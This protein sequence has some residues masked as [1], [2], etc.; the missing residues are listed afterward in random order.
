MQYTPNK[1][2]DL[3][4]VSV[5]RYFRGY[6]RNP[7]LIRGAVGA[8]AGP[9]AGRRYLSTIALAHPVARLSNPC[10]EEPVQLGIKGFSNAMS[11]RQRQAKALGWAEIERFLKSA[12]NTLPATRERALLCVA[13]DTM[14]RR[15]E[16]VALDLEDFN[17]LADGTGRALIR[18]SKTD[19]AGEGRI[20]YPSRTT[21]R[22]LNL[23]PKLK[24]AG[25][26]DGA[27]FRRVFGR[28]R[29]GG[30]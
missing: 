9:R 17:F 14:A 29:H 6:P 21:F 7:G 4:G 16:F 24:A 26:R 20:A 13:D 2:T 3:S 27:V 10:A 12:G 19:Q 30:R 25:T 28:G 15:S 1:V 18:R 5:V 22:Y 11:A 23:W 8:G